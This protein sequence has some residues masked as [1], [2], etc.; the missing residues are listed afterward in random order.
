MRTHS[1]AWRATV[2][3]LLLTGLSAS[4]GFVQAAPTPQDQK[5]SP[6]QTLQDLQSAR[7][8]AEARDTMASRET[9][10]LQ[11]QIVISKYQGEKKVSSLPYVLSL[12]SGPPGPFSSGIGGSL[13]MGTK[14]AIPSTSTND[15]K[16]VS[17]YQYRD[18]GTNID[19]SA[20]AR[21][22]G[23]FNVNVTVADSSVYPDD[24]QTPNVSGLPVLRSFE[25][26]NRL[27]LKDAQTAQFTAATDRVSGEVVKIDITLKVLK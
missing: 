27:I 3:G 10:P 18:I 14:V 26:T 7:Q 6:Q 19:C 13:R 1:G 24:K 8:L 22:D 20:T 17:S 2:I 5:P 25:V 21:P 4:T 16:T 23:A 15:G 11:F 9:I 12:N